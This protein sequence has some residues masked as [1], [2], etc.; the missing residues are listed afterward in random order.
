MNIHEIKNDIIKQFK[1][2]SAKERPFIVAIDGLGGAGKST[3]ANKLAEELK[4]ICAVELIHI[5]NHIVERNKRYNT[6]YDEWYEYYYLQ[7]DIDFIKHH[8]FLQLHNYNL[9]L[10]LPFYDQSTDVSC[11]KKITLAANSILIVEGIFLLRSEWR[12]FY[13]Y[14]L[15]IECPKTVREERVLQRDVYIGDFRT[16]LNKYR[17]RYWPAEEYYLE[18]EDPLAVADR[19]CDFLR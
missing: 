15:Y 13:D 3:I 17:R 6:G 12:S 5:D 7:W 1:A 14:S 9:E 19:I 10:K 11:N 2:R 4:I 18:K 8:V 16:R